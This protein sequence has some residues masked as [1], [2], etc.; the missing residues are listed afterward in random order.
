VIQSIQAS[1][2]LNKLYKDE[3]DNFNQICEIRLKSSELQES[4]LPEIRQKRVL[5][6]SSTRYVQ[7]HFKP[8]IMKLA[9]M[10]L[11]KIVSGMEWSLR[12]QI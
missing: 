8:K 9:S 11:H 12:R 4:N 10:K 1:K 5:A 6:K 7:N 2:R 3:V